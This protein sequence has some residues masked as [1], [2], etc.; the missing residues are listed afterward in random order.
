MDANSIEGIVGSELSKFDAR[1]KDDIRKR[2]VTPFAQVRAYDAC[3]SETVWIFAI[4]PENN[5]CLG[6]SES[7]YRGTDR[8]WG[9]MFFDK[10]WLGDSGAWYS[11]LAELVDDCGYF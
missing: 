9:L 1:L 8:N 2:F 11:D 10:L 7:G 5:V 6:F 4:I 3:D